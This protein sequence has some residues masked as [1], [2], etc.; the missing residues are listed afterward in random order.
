MRLNLTL[1]LCLVSAILTKAQT[2]TYNHYYGN[3]HAHSS[4]S[5]GNADAST[6][7]HTTP[8]QNYVYAN[9]SLPEG[10]TIVVS[11]LVSEDNPLRHDP[12]KLSA[13]IV[14]TF[15]SKDSLRRRREEEQLEAEAVGA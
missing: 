4:Y 15:Y 3:L 12:A 11:D 6:S 8:F 13:A 7:G 10:L 14:Q 9:G 2:T 5:D 1:I